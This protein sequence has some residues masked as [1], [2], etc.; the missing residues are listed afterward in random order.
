MVCLWTKETFGGQDSGIFLTSQATQH[1]H[2]A[3]PLPIGGR[4]PPPALQDHSGEQA[5]ETLPYAESIV[6]S[7]SY[8]FHVSASVGK[9][10]G[11]MCRRRT[12]TPVLGRRPI[13]LR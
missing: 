2:L 6:T 12:Q 8:A 13:N 10:D 11:I 5:E 7:G 9:S 3:G 1:T 4:H